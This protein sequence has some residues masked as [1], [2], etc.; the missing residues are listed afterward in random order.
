MKKAKAK[1]EE[2]YL[3]KCDACRACPAGKNDRVGVKFEVRKYFIRE[4]AYFTGVIQWF[5]S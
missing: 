5:S 4:G 1:D 2:V 3:V